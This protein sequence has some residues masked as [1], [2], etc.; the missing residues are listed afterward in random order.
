MHIY[1]RE[2]D[3]VCF[4]MSVGTYSICTYFTVVY[5]SDFLCMYDIGDIFLLIYEISIYS[6][7]AVH[8]IC[9]YL[10]E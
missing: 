4:I 6:S 2:N 3:G 5:V 7:I 1:C 8:N 9:I 10:K